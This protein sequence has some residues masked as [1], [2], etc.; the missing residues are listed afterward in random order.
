MKS[1]LI[2]VLLFGSIS[3]TAQDSL[4]TVKFF[5]QV[6]QSGSTISYKVY[7]N[8]TLI[9]RLAPGTVL[10]Y[11]CAAGRKTFS[12]SSD[13][14]GSITVEVKAGE[15]YF[16]ECKPEE[17]SASATPLMRPVAAGTVAPFIGNLNEQAV[18]AEN[19]IEI[20]DE[21][22]PSDTISAV[23]HLFKRKRK[24]GIARAI[25]F[26]ITSGLVFGNMVTVAVTDDPVGI[27]AADFIALG[28]FVGLTYHGGAQAHRYNVKT[29]ET[30]VNEYDKHKVLPPWVEKKLRPRDFKKK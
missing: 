17:G 23:T 29:L 12:A 11:K 28:A 6:Q 7:D 9:G 20:S 14:Q 24:S 8:E 1:Y 10:T 13:V 18:L 5:R 3:S 19:G 26:G 30:V 16:V 21:P 15:T 22:V 2:V 27:G 4:A 25:I